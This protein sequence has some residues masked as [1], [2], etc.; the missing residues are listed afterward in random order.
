MTSSGQIVKVV[1]WLQIG[2]IENVLVSNE[3]QGSKY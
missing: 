2:S 1:E 3:I